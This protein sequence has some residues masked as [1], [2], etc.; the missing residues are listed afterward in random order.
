MPGRGAGPPRLVI[1]NRGEIARRILRAGKARGFRV[2]VIS[3]VADLGAPVRREADAVLEVDDFLDG[4]AVVAAA[5]DWRADLLHPGYGFLSERADFAEAVET[6]GIAFVGPTP[7]AMRRLGGKETARRIAVE[8]GA[9]AL[10]GIPSARLARAA[11]PGAEVERGPVGFPCAVKAAFG[12][13]GIGIRVVRQ[14]EELDAALAAA[15][16]EAGSAFGDATVYVER[17]LDRPRHVEIQVFG[18]GEGGGVHFGERECSAQRRRQKLLEWT[19]AFGMTPA[20]R[21]EM[22]TAALRLVE[23]A[24]YRSAGTVEFLVDE[25]GRFWFLEVN[26]RLQVEHPVTEM[27]CDVDLV[28]AQLGLALG[29]WPEALPAASQPSAFV[30]PAPR[31]AAIEARILAE[32]P[33]RGFAPSPGWI[34]RYRAPGGGDVRVDSGIADGAPAPAGFDSLLA[35][36]IASGADLGEASATLRRALEETVI[37]GVET[38]V[39]FLLGMLEHPDFLAGRVHSGWVGSHLD[40]LTPSRMPAATGALLRR[41][42]VAQALAEAAS[43]RRRR[44]GATVFASVAGAGNFPGIRPG[45]RAGEVWMRRA[46]D[47]AE[48]RLEVTDLDAGRGVAV[49]AFGETLA[50]PPAENGGRTPGPSPDASSGGPR[51]GAIRAPV[52]GTLLRIRDEPGASVEAGEVVAILESMKMHWEVRAPAAGRLTAPAA[53]PGEAVAAGAALLTL[54][55]SPTPTDS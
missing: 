19:P 16:A 12:G 9:P 2:A 1:A 36:V 33:A 35:K 20:R 48:V 32:A 31:R 28:D 26:A 29:D 41:E 40:E 34:R 44:P 15:A 24:G 14:R 39:A 11:D 37:H 55:D 47:E 21:K 5:R 23:A 27:A 7:E 17:W 4:A 18:D 13:G 52:A 25:D 53:R 51:S 10:P 45:D 42:R 50:L 6:A 54:D 30:P 8:A 49:T 43:G 3:T 22:G 46:P 38:N